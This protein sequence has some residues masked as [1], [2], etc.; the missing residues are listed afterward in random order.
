MRRPTEA[1]FC[2]APGRGKTC[3]RILQVLSKERLAAHGPY[4]NVLWNQAHIHVE[5]VWDFG[6]KRRVCNRE[7]KKT[8]S[9]RVGETL[10]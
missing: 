6:N 5:E 1:F 4:Q 9:S 2:A 8:R 3:T 10:Y 7:E